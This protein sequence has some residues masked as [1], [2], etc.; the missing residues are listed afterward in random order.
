MSHDTCH[1][2]HVTCHVSCVTCHVSHVTCQASCVTFHMSHVI[3]FLLL[4]RT[5]WW[6]LLVEGLL[7]AGPTLSSLMTKISYYDHTKT[8]CWVQT[9]GVDRAVTRVKI[10]H[11]SGSFLIYSLK[12]I[13]DFLKNV[14]AFLCYSFLKQVFLCF[15][16]SISPWCYSLRGVLGGLS[17]HLI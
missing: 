17:I 7:S 8:P 11:Y 13:A 4:F 14:K 6:S 2:T 12:I 1:V 10:I 15:F 5:K 16:Q 9:S 3:F